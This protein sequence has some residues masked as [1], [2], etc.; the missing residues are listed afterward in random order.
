MTEDTFRLTVCSPEIIS[1]V[2]GLQEGKTATVTLTLEVTRREG[3]VENPPPK[4]E[5]NMPM[6]MGGATD[7]NKQT[8]NVVELSGNVKSMMCKGKAVEAAMEDDE[9][10][11]PKPKKSGKPAKASVMAAMED[12]ED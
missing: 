1:A 11:E 8:Y 4:S 9:E 10:E 2:K 5:K 6:E 12:E 3:R 7:M